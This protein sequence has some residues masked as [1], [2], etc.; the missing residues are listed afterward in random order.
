MSPRPAM[1]CLALVAACGGRPVPPDPAPAPPLTRAP[2]DSSALL[3]AR[4]DSLDRLAQSR[5]AAALEAA[6]RAAQ[7]AALRDTLT[8]RVHFDFDRAEIRDADRQ[9]LDRKAAILAGNPGLRLRV[10]GHCDT[11]GSDEYNLA[12]GARRAASVR[13]YLAA[14]GITG[15]R[16][17]VASFG[18]ER[19]LD[20]APT[21]WAWA[22]N[23][24]GEFHATGL[25]D[26]LRM[27]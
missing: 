12:L 21:E 3:A 25:P 2:V 9:L 27:P 15:D 26:T 11:R 20:P 22:R 24:R 13:R 17:E 10:E 16:V 14:H 6:Q 4:R 7:S 19:P 23:R 18:E 1:L 8:L 5:R